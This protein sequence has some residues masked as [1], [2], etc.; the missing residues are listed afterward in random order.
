MQSLVD[1]KA[2]NNQKK[3]K[4][5]LEEKVFLESLSKGTSI[6]KACQAADKGI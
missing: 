1:K 3:E 5:K 6:I 2:M 4:K